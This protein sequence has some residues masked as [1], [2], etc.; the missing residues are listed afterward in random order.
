MA[1]M[2]AP[3]S[4]DLTFRASVVRVGGYVCVCVHMC[5]FVCLCVS[6]SYALTHTHTITGHLDPVA[7]R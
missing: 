4:Y 7:V 6:S 5:V 2:P 1:F 3:S